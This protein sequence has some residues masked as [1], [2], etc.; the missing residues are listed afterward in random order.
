MKGA[1]SSE[2]PEFRGFVGSAEREG[3]ALPLA[4]SRTRVTT[5][6]PERLVGIHGDRLVAG[7]HETRDFFVQLVNSTVAKAG[8][9]GQ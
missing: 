7:G 1:L 4:A 2:I 6:T 3:R 5:S 9:H 8:H